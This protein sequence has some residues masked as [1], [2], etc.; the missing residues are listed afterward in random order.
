[1]DEDF[2]RHLGSQQSPVATGSGVTLPEV[3]VPS[4]ENRTLS[5]VLLGSVP[6]SVERRVREFHNSVAAIF[7]TWVSR[8]ESAHTRRAYRQDVMT[9]VRF[10]GWS[11]PKDSTAML[12]VSVQDVLAFRE[13]LVESNAAPK[14][15][16]RRISSLSVF[17]KYLAGAAAEMRLPITGSESGPCAIRLTGLHRSRQRGALAFRHTR[18]ATY[19][20]AVWGFSCGSQGQGDPKILPLLRRTSRH[21]MSTQGCRLSP[22]W[23]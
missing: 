13:L 4:I 3:T 17:Y 12:T 6:P 20:D 14:T 8:R 15:I 21:G 16:N 19:G 5:P 9:F 11:W 23:R 7:E 10:M 2:R 18:A 1:M 22:R